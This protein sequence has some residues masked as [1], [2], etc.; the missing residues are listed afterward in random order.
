MN[1]CSRE[2]HKVGQPEDNLSSS[3][4][5]CSKRTGLVMSMPRKVEL[6]WLRGE[7]KRD[8]KRALSMRMTWKAYIVERQKKL[9]DLCIQPG[10]AGHVQKSCKGQVR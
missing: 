1:E 5:K 9:Q 2:M 3:F 7:T 10:C 6:W 8:G 4:L